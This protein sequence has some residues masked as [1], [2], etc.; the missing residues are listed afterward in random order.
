MK[1]FPASETLPSCTMLDVGEVEVRSR[2]PA[3]SILCVWQSLMESPWWWLNSKRHSAQCSQSGNKPKCTG[4]GQSSKTATVVHNT[5]SVLKVWMEPQ[6]D[7]PQVQLIL[8]PLFIPWW[9][10]S[11]HSADYIREGFLFHYDLLL[12]LFISF[13]NFFSPPVPT[14][15]MSRERNEWQIDLQKEPPSWDSGL[16]LQ[17]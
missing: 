15:I 8:I 2:A 1:V 9:G 12:G 13:G 5:D 3:V 11:K 6:Q 4:L 7:R 10:H 17:F 16:K 14:I